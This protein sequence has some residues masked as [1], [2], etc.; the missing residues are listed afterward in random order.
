MNNGEY[1]GAGSGTTKL[2]LH[3]NGN[4]LDS[5]GNGNN[6]TDTDVTYSLANGKLGQGAGFNGSSSRIMLPN[7]TTLSSVTF[8]A[9]IKLTGNAPVNAAYITN[10]QGTNS[11]GVSIHPTGNK[12]NTIIYPATTTN[13]YDNTGANMNDSTWHHVVSTWNGTTLTL[14]KD[15]TFVGSMALTATNAGGSTSSIGCNGNGIANTFFPGSI[16]EVL[17]ENRGWTAEE[18]KRYYT[19]AKGRYAIL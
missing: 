3:L 11:F 1:I 10:L 19:Y 7:M 4:S 5:S 8:S 6:G 9:W 18:I 13:L 15:G 14:Y 16:D 17:I 12:L 2:L